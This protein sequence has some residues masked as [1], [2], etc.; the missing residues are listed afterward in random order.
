MYQAKNLA[1]L[2]A[3][4]LPEAIILSSAAFETIH[5]FARIHNHLRWKLV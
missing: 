3:I 5:S 1:A 4:V 2:D